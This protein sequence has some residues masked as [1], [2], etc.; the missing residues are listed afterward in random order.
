MKTKYGACHCN[1]LTGYLGRDSWV[2]LW[3]ENFLKQDTTND[4]L[5]LVV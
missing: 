4:L 3:V 5:F 1:E 2:T